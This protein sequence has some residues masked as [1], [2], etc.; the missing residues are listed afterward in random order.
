M[1]KYI[2]KTHNAG[3]IKGWNVRQW[4]HSIIYYMFCGTSLFIKFL[5]C[6]LLTNTSRFEGGS[7]QRNRRKR[8]Q[9]LKNNLRVVI[10]K[11]TLSLHKSTCRHIDELYRNFIIYRFNSPIKK[12]QA[13]N[14]EFEQQF[15]DSRIVKMRIKKTRLKKAFNV[16]ISFNKRKFKLTSGS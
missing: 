11:S 4:Q 13:A 5:V 14:I 2:N 8:R 1:K 6:L 9:L 16:R 7:S 12:S 10:I 15:L 3:L